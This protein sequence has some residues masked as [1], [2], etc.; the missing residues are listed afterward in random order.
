MFHY[1]SGLVT[2]LFPN[3]AVIDCSGVGFEVN[4][5]AYTL[6]QLK[7]GERAKL[8]TYVHI[9]E[10]A[11]EIYG[12]S[13]KSEKRCFEML[14]GVSGVGPKAALSILSVST[15][16][17]LIMS[18]VSGDERAITAAAGVGKKIAQRVILELKDKLAK[19]TESVSFADTS[20]FMPAASSDR[21]KLGDA[22]AALT[23]LGY[24]A[25]E[26]NAALKGVDAGNMTT[27]EIVKAALK[28]MM[29]ERR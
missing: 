25:P 12:F 20:A 23:V 21:S 15:P 17:N 5:S 2:E 29:M 3:L 18:I 13:G 16:E 6:S 7:A 24:S 22:A 4:T 1:L 8:Y 26:I 28:Q 27:E 14:L 11:F 19:E 10:D 9:R